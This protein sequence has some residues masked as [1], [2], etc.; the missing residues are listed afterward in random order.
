MKRSKRFREMAEK[1]D[2]DKLYS[3][4][5][6]VDLLQQCPPVKFDQTVEIS[7]KTGIDAK[8][9]DQQVRGT[10][11]LP[12]GTGK[13][14]VV[15]VFTQGD[16]VKLAMEAGAEFAGS[17][18]LIEKVK[19]GWIGFDAVVASPDMMRE[20]GKLGKVLG[21]RGL[22]P[23]PKAGT[24]TPDVVKAVK[25]LKGGKIEFKSDKHGVINSIVG[26]ISFE[27]DKLVENIHSL[28]AA[29][30]RT[31]PASTKG[32][33]LVSMALSSTMGLGFKIDTQT[34][35]TET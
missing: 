12:H 32:Q 31:R 35:A 8:K 9:S 23:T 26:K 28:L 3:L 34:L 24:V 25:E 19:G 10:I 1:L 33:F 13:R 29:I 20:V 18:E 4:E 21:P 22:M 6:A 14:L 16:K 15:L 30:S 17:N 27:K 7:L 5:E 11:S 2:L